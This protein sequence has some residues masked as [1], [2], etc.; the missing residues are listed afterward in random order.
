MLNI[1]IKP[2][3]QCNLRCKH[4]YNG[5]SCLDR[6]DIDTTA[7]F[8]TSLFA[9]NGDGENWLIFHGGEPLLASDEQ[10]KKM[11][12]IHIPGVSKRITTNLAMPLS[13]A[14]KDMLLS[15]DD[16]RTS[17]DAG[18]GRFTNIKHFLHWIHNIKWCYS[19]DVHLTT[20]NVCLSKTI[21]KVKTEKLLR[22]VKRLGFKKLSL[23]NLC[24]AGR[25]DNPGS[26]PSP[27]EVDDW[28]LE[29]Y[30]A[31]KDTGIEIV[32][33]DSLK[34]GICGDWANYRGIECCK[35]TLT[36]NANGT[37][38]ECPNSARTNIIGSIFSD[39]DNI[40]KNHV[41]TFHKSEHFKTCLQCSYFKYCKGGCKEQ[42]WIDG[43]CSYPK[44][45][46][47]AIRRDIFN[48]ENV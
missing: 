24:L 13:K 30:E 28:M 33:F 47:D 39:A 38:G 43:M 42:T 6:L 7:N 11:M 2:T 18:L 44:K 19:N 45:T 29:L 12:D 32:N 23:E 4:C 35:R 16:V 48:H 37:I 41:C 21:I 26:I 10:L 40:L 22:M 9:K 14:M 1:Y 17:F 34:A 31:A 15:L 8:L 20:I 25:L 27:A 46:A 3:E 5:E 36:I